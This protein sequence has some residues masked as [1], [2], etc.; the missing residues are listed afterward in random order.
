M[1]P[2]ENCFA[3]AIRVLRRGALSYY[4]RWVPSRVSY[5]HYEPIPVKI[6]FKKNFKI[7]R[8][9]PYEGALKIYV[10]AVNNAALVSFLYND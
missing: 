6:V 10:V 7:G 9:L 8:R 3:S 5:I 2:V 1:F 4:L